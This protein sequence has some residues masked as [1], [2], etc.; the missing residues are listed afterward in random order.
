MLS[1]CE[2]VE[3]RNFMQTVCCSCWQ[4]TEYLIVICMIIT[5]RR[6]QQNVTFVL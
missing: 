6:L 1:F 4:L 3:D 5:M 2:L